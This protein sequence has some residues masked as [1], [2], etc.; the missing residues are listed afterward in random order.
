MKKLIILACVITH[1]TNV[2]AQLDTSWN[3]TPTVVFTN[4]NVGIGKNNPSAKLDI[5]GD[6]K[7]SSGSSYLKITNNR[8]T[9]SDNVIF[10]GDSS[11]IF[12]NSVN[13]IGNSP[14]SA[15]F[16]PINGLT[17]GNSSITAANTLAQGLNSIAIGYNVSVK[18]K[19][20]YAI[21]MGKNM[22][23]LSTNSL[24]IGF[25]S[26]LGF[27]TPTLFVGPELMPG[28]TGNIGIGT[29][30]PEDKL[31]MRFQNDLCS[32]AIGS[33]CSPGLNHGTAY[34][35]FNAVRTSAGT[36]KTYT[37]LG[38]NGG[39]ILYGNVAGNFYFTT[40][41]VA[42]GGT[43]DQ[44]GIT[45]GTV[46][47]NTKLFIDGSSGRVGMGTITPS[48][49]LDVVDNSSV[50][51]GYTSVAHVNH[52]LTKCWSVIDK[53]SGTPKENFLVYGSGQV[54][55][56]EIFVKLTT[57]GDF[58]FEPDYK[59]L[60]YSELRNYIRKHKHLPKIPSENE[61]VST[62][63]N[64]GEMQAL[65]LQKT[66]EAHLY[67]LDLN[68]RLEVLEKENEELKALVKQLIDKK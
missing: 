29:S 60:S 22:L 7:I 45:D 37:D 62:N 11:L 47:N 40:I 30:A 66:E 51:F 49:T 33:A 68:T 14:T 28:V 54:Y 26:T 10:F 1:F 65:T 31:Q 39:A 48:A 15:P 55:A 50:M 13:Q 9:S 17:L 46:F 36:W 6:L 44:T 56:R 2:N 3:S 23:N 24:A 61:V 16:G 59:L 12:A 42:G 53:S 25:N 64:V 5:E 27:S 21:S 38:N 18:E 19:I 67:I 32:F 43:S 4:K 8:I 57:L 20:D 63:L 52:P 58:V 35:G 34:L 41:P